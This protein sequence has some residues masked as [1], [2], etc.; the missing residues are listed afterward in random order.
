MPFLCPQ[1]W[2]PLAC[3]SL[4]MCWGG[5]LLV[6]VYASGGVCRGCDWL[7]LLVTFLI[8]LNGEY[9]CF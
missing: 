1:L 9:Q 7:G 8:L 6:G 5:C 2:L 4:C 3:L